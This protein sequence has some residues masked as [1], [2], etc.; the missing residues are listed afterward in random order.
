VYP[1]SHPMGG[2][3]LKLLA[4]PFWIKKQFFIAGNHIKKVDL[5]RRITTSKSPS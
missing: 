2:F 1:E 3:Q 4:I 5:L